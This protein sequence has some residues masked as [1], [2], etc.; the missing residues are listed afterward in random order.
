MIGVVINDAIVMIAKI[1]DELKKPSENIFHVIATTAST[2]LR[3]VVLTTLTTVAGVLPT[4]YG[5]AG[6]D[7]M[8][9]EMMLTMGWGL[10]F[11]TI[12]TLIL[13]PILYS[14]T[15]KREA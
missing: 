13:I 12:I 2:R 4:A 3:A 5:V 8:L 11:G 6:F 9:S 14:Y 15:K 7:S 10:L 1:E